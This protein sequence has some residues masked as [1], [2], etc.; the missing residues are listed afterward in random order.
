MINCW[1]KIALFWVIKATLFQIYG[2]NIPKI[3]TLVPGLKDRALCVIAQHLTNL[4][5]ICAGCYF[6]CTFTHKEPDFCGFFARCDKNFY[7]VDNRAQCLCLSG[8]SER[9]S[10]MY[11]FFANRNYW[12]VEVILRLNQ[13]ASYMYCR[14][15]RRRLTEALCIM[16]PNLT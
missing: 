13:N 6:A 10:M 7:V 1:H 15:L 9:S 11:S 4:R 2:E 12:W 16:Y 5:C 14:S 3:I 8:K